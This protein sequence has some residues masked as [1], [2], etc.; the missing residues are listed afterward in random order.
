MHLKDCVLLKTKQNQTN[1][2]FVFVKTTASL[3]DHKLFPS[4]LRTG[5]VLPCGFCVGLFWLLVRCQE[6]CTADAEKERPPIT[7]CGASNLCF[8]EKLRLQSNNLV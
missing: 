3:P 1:I 5:K 4:A 6:I 7:M 8:K 2:S